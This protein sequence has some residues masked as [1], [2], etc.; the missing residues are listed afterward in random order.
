MFYHPIYQSY[1]GVSKNNGTPKSYILISLFHYKQSIL[2]APLFLETPICLLYHYPIGDCWVFSAPVFRFMKIFSKD[3]EVK[4]Q[5]SCFWWHLSDFRRLYIVIVKDA[6]LK[7][8]HF[9]SSSLTGAVHWFP[10]DMAVRIWR[11][12]KPERKVGNLQNMMGYN[13]PTSL[14]KPSSKIRV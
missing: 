13:E 3:Y 7:S 4:W 9:Y 11:R 12:S 5:L 1:M 14:T 2:G 8:P 6:R 10:E